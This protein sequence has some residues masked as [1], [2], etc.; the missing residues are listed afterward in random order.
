ME[1]DQGGGVA[2][3]HMGRRAGAFGGVPALQRCPGAGAPDRRAWQRLRGRAVRRRRAVALRPRVGGA[4]TASGWAATEAGERYRL[5]ASAGSRHAVVQAP[6]AV[7]LARLGLVVPVRE[8]RHARV[9][10]AEGV[11]EAAAAQQPVAKGP[12]LLLRACQPR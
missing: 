10:R 6:A 1:R 11:H 3:A 2:G 7:A 9:L 12:P 8:P 5:R 4:P